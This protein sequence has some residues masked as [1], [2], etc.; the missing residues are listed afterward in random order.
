[1]QRLSLALKLPTRQRY[2]VPF[3]CLL[4]IIDM[5]AQRVTARNSS[6]A[7]QALLPNCDN[8]S[9][10]NPCKAIRLIRKRQHAQPIAKGPQV[11]RWRPCCF[12]SLLLVYCRP[13]ACGE[14]GTHAGRF[15]DCRG[16]GVLALGLTFAAAKYIDAR[17]ERRRQKAHLNSRS[18]HFGKLRRA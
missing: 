9:G 17:A 18:P 3:E 2:T 5:F 13:E 14:C 6:A 15:I 16:V 12:N 8:N 1:L 4:A 11:L 7:R 10:F